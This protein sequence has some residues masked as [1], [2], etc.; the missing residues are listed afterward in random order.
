MLL[1]RLIVLPLLGA[2]PLCFARDKNSREI[3]VWAF[4]VTLLTFIASLPVWMYDPKAGDLYQFVETHDWIKLKGG[5]LTIGFN[6]GVDGIS[7]LMILLTTFIMPIA[8]L[9]A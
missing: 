9:G 5:G 4:L 1:T 7:S 3:K 2:I 8:I 6:L